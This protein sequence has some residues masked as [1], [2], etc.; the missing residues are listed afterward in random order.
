MIYEMRTYTLRPGTVPEAL[1]KFEKAYS[2][3]K[4][5]KAMAGLFYTDIGPVNQLIQIWP[6][7]SHAE[8]EAVRAET[9]N[10]KDWPP[11]LGDVVQKQEVEVYDPF[12]YVTCFEPGDYGPIYEMRYYEMVIGDMGKTMKSWEAALPER[13]SRSPMVAAMYTDIGPLNKMVHIWPYRSFKD[14]TEIRDK[15]VADKIW[16]PRGAN[17]P[18]VIQR[19]KIMYPA[20]FS[21]MQ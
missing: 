17:A 2:T 16:P 18:P 13:T 20:S 6:F 12:P 5:F 7:E 3:Y 4:D 10:R 9:P 1:E 15:A 21:P 8:R 14:R 19:N 11:G